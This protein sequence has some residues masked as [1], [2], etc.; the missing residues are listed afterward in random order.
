MSAAAAAAGRSARRHLTWRA[1]VVE[2]RDGGDDARVARLQQWLGG[3]QQQPQ[4]GL[5]GGRGASARSAVTVAVVELA[6]CLAVGRIL[7]HLFTN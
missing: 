7:L 1:M 5:H 4:V 6:V 3:A 2:L